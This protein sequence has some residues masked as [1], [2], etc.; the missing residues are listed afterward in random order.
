MAS[1]YYVTLDYLLLSQK[2]ISLILVAYF[3]SGLVAQP[4]EQQLSKSK[5]HVLES[6]PSKSFSLP[7]GGLICLPWVQMG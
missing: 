3:Y 2:I 5:G 4:V 6:H 1:V 7:L